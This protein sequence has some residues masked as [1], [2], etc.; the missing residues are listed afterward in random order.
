MLFYYLIYLIRAPLSSFY[1]TNLRSWL[2]TLEA[3]SNIYRFDNGIYPTEIQQLIGSDID[4]ESYIYPGGWQ[5]GKPRIEGTS[6]GVVV[7]VED[8][9]QGITC[10]RGLGS[11]T[12]PEGTK[13][14][15]NGEYLP[16]YLKLAE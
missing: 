3:A 12:F 8:M 6:E 5:F 7:T 13:C 14:Y 11:L 1:P 16:D 10:S 15:Q 2:S 9:Y 4:G